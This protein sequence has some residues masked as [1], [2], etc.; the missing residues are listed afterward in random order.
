ML[1]L[2]L[3]PRRGEGEI[4]LDTPKSKVSVSV[5]SP[6]TSM[7]DLLQ[8]MLGQHISHAEIPYGDSMFV[9][10]AI[11]FDSVESSKLTVHLDK[12]TLDAI[13]KANE[14]LKPR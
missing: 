14:K 3:P 12:V 6:D 11:V 10:I 13:H 7:R 4:R 8:F 9:H 2:K 5:L 1:K